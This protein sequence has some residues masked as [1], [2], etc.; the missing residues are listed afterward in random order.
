MIQLT[1]SQHLALAI[2]RNILI[3][4]GAGSGKTTIIIERFLKLLATYPDLDPTA[5]LIITFTKLAAL[6][7]KQRIQDRLKNNTHQLNPTRH[8]QLLSKLHRLSFS[9]IDSFCATTLRQ[10][11]LLADID[12]HFRVISAE[13]STLRYEDAIEITLRQLAHHADSHYETLLY[14]YSKAQIKRFLNA[15]SLQRHSSKNQTMA[16]AAARELC[17]SHTNTTHHL[18][19]KAITD[20]EALLKLHTDVL[21]TYTSNKSRDSAL[22]YPD[23]IDTTLELLTHHDALRALQNQYRYIFVDEFQDTNSSQWQLIQRLCDPF[24]PFSAQKLCIVGDIKQS[25]Y[26]FRGAEPQLFQSL[27]TTDHPDHETTI[28]HLADNFRSTPPIIQFI[29]D[30]F[31]QLLTDDHTPIPYT[32]LI[33][34]YT[35]SGAVSFSFLPVNASLND[36]CDQLC[37]WLIKMH[38]SGIQWNDMA[39]LCRK[40]LPLS[41]L[42]E[43]LKAQ[44]IPIQFHGESDYFQRQ[45]CVD[46]MTLAQTLLNPQDPIPLAGTLLSPFMTLTYDDLYL[47]SQ[48]GP[49]LFTTMTQ[50][51]THHY[52][53]LW[54]QI[55]EQDHHRILTN[56]QRLLD[57]ISAS[58]YKP[59]HSLLT[60]IIIA[61]NCY[62]KDELGPL[63]DHIY[64]LE[65]MNRTRVMIWQQ[66]SQLPYQTSHYTDMTMDHKGVNLMTIHQSKGLEFQAVGIMSCH[67]PFNFGKS[68]P[69]IVSSYGIGLSLP[70][71]ESET[72]D[73][74]TSLINQLTPDI[75][76]E[77]K[78]L[79]YVACTRAIKSLF[80]SGITP[81]TSSTTTHRSFYDF[82]N[83]Y[84]TITPDSLCLN[85]I[86]YPTYHYNPL[87][88][89]SYTASTG[90]STTPTTP[91]TS[92]DNQAEFIQPPISPVIDDNGS[93]LL[94]PLSFSV[95]DIELLLTSP[96]HYKNRSLHQLMQ[97]QGKE[98]IDHFEM[99]AI[100]RGLIHH[101]AAAYWIRH[102]CT[103]TEA[104]NTALNHWLPNHSKETFRHIQQTLAALT[105][106]YDPST[107]TEWPF[108]IHINPNY[109]ISGRIDLL[110]ITDDAITIVDIKTDQVKIKEINKYV[111][112]YSH[113][114]CL[115]VMAVAA[116]T[117]RPETDIVC[118]LYFTHCNCWQTLHITL[119]DINLLIH[120]LQTT[121]A[122]FNSP[123]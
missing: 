62:S 104:I 48:S 17:Q 3:E 63:I 5:I 78:R 19:E 118:K 114:L 14:T 90:S 102:R 72:N 38:E 101:Q 94:P 53:E 45:A 95:A 92:S 69:L 41:R 83:H 7:L 6:E 73:L 113:Q 75:I 4:A 65:S 89:L 23:L 42:S 49:C 8:Q 22:D 55:L 10:M 119:A 98:S 116:Y 64:Q 36:E 99:T 81:K 56:I 87:N 67:S 58:H 71:T 88:P 77:E 91:Q 123:K 112:K 32:P 107:L 33:P 43:R 74:K 85:H 79:F 117:K 35:E 15:L 84:S 34:H 26:R 115:Y 97:S 68:D 31:S 24:N 70:N 110:A 29:N 105:A 47:L 40:R 82:L 44:Q 51:N 61:T 20:T 28:I 121:L 46:L 9:T 111:I 11:P 60:E 50:I 106:Y 12:P 100:R 103:Q 76:A 37:Q 39:I 93:L 108:T 80:L 59:L 120:K 96:Q 13:E 18:T 57:W 122:H 16:Y 52:P 2:D 25:I 86:H 1:H 66:L 30:L 21:N 109:H 27:L 54:S